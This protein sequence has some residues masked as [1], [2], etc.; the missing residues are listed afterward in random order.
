MHTLLDLPG[1][2]PTF[3]ALHHRLAGSLRPF[4]PHYFTT[5]V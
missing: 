2:I 1:N 3:I 4:L 5:H